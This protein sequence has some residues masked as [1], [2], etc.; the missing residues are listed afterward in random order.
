MTSRRRR[1]WFWGAV[2]VAIVLVTA[3]GIG[4]HALVTWDPRRPFVKDPRACPKSNVSLDEITG[5]FGF[6]IPEDATGVH[7]FSDLHPLFGEYSLD[8]SFQ[9]SA[10]GLKTFLKSSGLPK[11]ERPD[12]SGAALSLEGP[13]CGF[14]MTA[15]HD[16]R[17]S[18][19]ESVSS[20]SF[21][22]Q[23]AVDGTD[24][25]KPRVVLSALDL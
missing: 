5:H 11:P 7:F 2:A 15:L 18:S 20:G 17:Y 12:D 10:G 6:V 1:G 24:T 13:S 25:A 4:V 9:T 8:M 22:R 14:G 19:D 21:E 23:V 3:I 16:P